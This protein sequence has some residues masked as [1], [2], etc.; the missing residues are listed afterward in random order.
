MKFVFFGY[1][2]SISVI[3]RL[4]KDGHTPISIFTFPCDNVFNF[5]KDL[6]TLAQQHNIP[7]TTNTVTPDDIYLLTLQGAELFLA[8]G[9]THK[10][11]PIDEGKAY[12]LN[13][14]PALLPMGRGLMP[15]PTI[16]MEHPEAGGLTVHKLAPN[17]DAG[18]ILYQETVEITDHTTVDSYSAEIA[19]RSP[20]I[21]SKIVADLPNYWQNARKQDKSKAKTFKTPTDQTRTLNWSKP[22]SQI[23]RTL[24]AFGSFGCLAKI[25]G[26]GYGIFA[27]KIEKTPHDFDAGTLVNI[28][29]KGIKIAAG[30]GEDT[31]YILLTKYQI[32]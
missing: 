27:H 13:T 28:D 6:I 11:P 25:N 19:K 12:G 29:D 1:D 5:N 10:I 16:I 7:I 22:L 8:C 17:F 18:D 4:I 24:R 15:T 14:H 20:A 32:L 31:G 26:Q 23:D 30:T 21:I 2:F 3:K 9:Y